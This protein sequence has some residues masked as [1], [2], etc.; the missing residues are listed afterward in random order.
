M[1]DYSFA[2]TKLYKYLS[3]YS[4]NLKYF[5]VS[6]YGTWSKCQ[7][8]SLTVELHVREHTAFVNR[9]IIRLLKFSCNCAFLDKEELC[10]KVVVLQL[11]CTQ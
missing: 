8:F 10:K 4:Q 11:F 3:L 7:F 2:Q 9:Q 6:R 5:G 1:T